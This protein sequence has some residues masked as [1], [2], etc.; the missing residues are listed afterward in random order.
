VRL[1][2]KAVVSIGLSSVVTML[3]SMLRMKVVAVELG[4]G[5]IGILGILTTSVTLASTALGGGLGI[6]GV[7]AVAS[8]T[9]HD[10]QRDSVHVAV[11]R[12]S[13]LLAS[14]AAP[15]V[16][17][18]WWL[19]G[20]SIVPQ[21]PTSVVAPW[22][23][24]SVG[25][26]IG[27]AGTSAIL[28]GQGRI[29]ALASST[30]LG[31]V[32]G[33]LIFFA[34][35]RLSH[36]WGMIAAFAA[37]PVATLVFGLA[38]ARAT[39]PRGL[40]VRRQAWTPHLSKMLKLGLAVS[41]SVVLTAG[42]Q[43]ISRVWVSHE[44]GISEAGYLQGSLAVGSA[45]L[46]FVLTA[47][48]AEYYP[49]ISALRG[50]RDLSNRT[51]NDQVRV[52]L[53]LGGPV[54]VCMI[55]VAP[56]L[57]PLLYNQEFDSA[58]TL[59]RLLLIGDVFKLVGWCVGFLMLAREAKGKFF[60]T[61]LSWNLVF[62]AVLV[63]LAHRGV[64]VAGLAYVISYLLF[65][66]VSLALARRETGFELSRESRRAA[67]WVTAAT[68]VAF[69]ASESGSRVG[70]AVALVTAAVCTVLATTRVLGWIRRDSVELTGPDTPV[71]S[72][73]FRRES[74]VRRPRHT[75]RR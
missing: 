38:L 49:R 54:I 2:L 18:A 21:A 65:S 32:T 73:W 44:L 17:A 13:V 56:W 64:T 39:Y 59:L 67:V 33:T 31:S 16:C 42:T 43:V 19:W 9:N 28:N 6:S 71:E 26:T 40:K 7:R 20:S 41:G 51:V 72:A 35:I 12:G 1:I 63:P 8:A 10:G 3:L 68:L 27:V 74:A 45:Y 4:A 53:H 29:G 58:V 37:V 61:E 25:A 60:V 36:E 55:V 70:L 50:D 11:A 22:V 75:L 15:L 24:V 52:V 47:L 30:A 48:A 62:L 57:L 69:G 66:F 46:G 23:G 5:G 34:A 14:L